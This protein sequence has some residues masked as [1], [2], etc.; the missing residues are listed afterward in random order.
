VRPKREQQQ[1]LQ[2]PGP[3]LLS[4]KPGGELAS[5]DDETEDTA[6][7]LHAQRYIGATSQQLSTPQTLCCGTVVEGLVPTQEQ[8]TRG[9]Y[10]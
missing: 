6:C 5:L 2:K 4:G 3:L 9:G 10:S 8:D 1:P 7:I